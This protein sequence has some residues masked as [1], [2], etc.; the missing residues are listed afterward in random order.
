[1]K[2]WFEGMWWQKKSLRRRKICSALKIFKELQCNLSFPRYDMMRMEIKEI[3]QKTN[4]ILPSKIQITSLIMWLG[5]L[6]LL[7]VWFKTLIK[8]RM[9]PNEKAEIKII[10]DVDFKEKGIKCIWI[11]FLQNSSKPLPELQ[12][13]PSWNI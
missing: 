4:K 1:M 12:V 9:G 2:S 13:C 6:H 11:D 5:S 10:Q 7:P 3:V 8:R